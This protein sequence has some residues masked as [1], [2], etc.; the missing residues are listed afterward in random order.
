MC[1]LLT[2]F[3]DRVSLQRLQTLFRIGH[4]CRSN[5]AFAKGVVNKLIRTQIHCINGTVR[6][7]I[8][9]DDGRLACKGHLGDGI[10]VLESSRQAEH[11]AGSIRNLC[12]SKHFHIGGKSI[13]KETVTP[14]FL[15]LRHHMDIVRKEEKFF[16][17]VVPATVGRKHIVFLPRIG[18]EPE[19]SKI[20]VRFIHQLP[21]LDKNGVGEHIDIIL[22]GELLDLRIICS[23]AALDDLSILVAH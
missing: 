13:E 2:E 5:I 20:P 6:F 14:S 10:D 1:S 9:R 17:T 22:E 7:F 16:R 11:I 15:I 21:G 8:L 18:S 19:C 4:R 3:S 23:V 12:I